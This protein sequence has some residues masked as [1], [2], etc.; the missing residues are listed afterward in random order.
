M[1]WLKFGFGHFW[2]THLCPSSALIVITLL[3]LW[4]QVKGR[5]LLAEMMVRGRCY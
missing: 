5:D 2:F 4:D 3:I 1:D